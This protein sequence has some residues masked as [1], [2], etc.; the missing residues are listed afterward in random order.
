MP[1]PD[2]TATELELRLQV[3][4]ES[5][6]RGRL[7]IDLVSLLIDSDI[8]RASRYAEEAVCLARARGDRATSPAAADA[9]LREG[10]ARIS[11]WWASR[12]TG[13]SQHQRV[14]LNSGM[15]PFFSDTG[16]EGFEP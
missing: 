9:A 11:H 14:D 1:H 3:V 16:S 12:D 2:A 15:R 4:H 8:S 5:T 10:D 13:G 6:D 7:L